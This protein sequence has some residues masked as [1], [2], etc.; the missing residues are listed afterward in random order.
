MSMPAPAGSELPLPWTRWLRFGYDAAGNQTSVVRADGRHAE[1][2]VVVD[3]TFRGE[4]R[5]AERRV[6]PAAPACSGASC[7]GA[8]I[9]RHYG[10]EEGT[11]WC[12][13]MIARP[14]RSANC[15]IG[16][17]SYDGAGRGRL[18]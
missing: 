4:W 12:S 15:R 9:V 7:A 8:P 17:Q 11:V 18:R 5:P 14:I 2:A 10:Y 3:A 1:G 16:A 6:F 13:K